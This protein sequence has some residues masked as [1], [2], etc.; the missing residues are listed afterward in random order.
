MKLYFL[1]MIVRMK[2]KQHKKKIFLNPCR[3]THK[4]FSHPPI[5]LSYK[6]TR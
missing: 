3:I 2:D 6:F 5:L 1:K 4:N